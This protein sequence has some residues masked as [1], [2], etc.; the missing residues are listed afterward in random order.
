MEL[1]AEWPEAGLG[2]ATVNHFQGGPFFRD[3]QN[4]FPQRQIVGDDVGDGLRFAGAG[5]TMEDEAFPGSRRMDSREL[6]RIGT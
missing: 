4:R 2:Q 3:E 1:Q 6:R 5:R